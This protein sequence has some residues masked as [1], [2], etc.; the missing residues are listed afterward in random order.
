MSDI[1]RRDFLK[2]GSAALAGLTIAPTI[3][4]NTVLGKKYN[5]KAP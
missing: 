2:K 3:V 4:P 5:H 1:S